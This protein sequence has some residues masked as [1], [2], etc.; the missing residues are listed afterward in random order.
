MREAAGPERQD[1][2]VCGKV[3]YRVLAGFWPVNRFRFPPGRSDTGSQSTQIYNS[4]G[5]ALSPACASA[6]LRKRKKEGLNLL[7][8][9]LQSGCTGSLSAGHE[10]FRPV[11]ER[12][13]LQQ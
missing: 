9:S 13:Q 3:P 10:G 8:G 4:K 1:V 7:V 6:H 11:C 5:S 2:R 12:V